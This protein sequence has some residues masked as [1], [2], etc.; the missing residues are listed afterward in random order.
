MTRDYFYII[1]IGAWSHL[2]HRCPGLF[3]LWFFAGGKFTN[4]DQCYTG[5]FFQ[6]VLF[7]ASL[8][9]CNLPFFY[10]NSTDSQSA[11][12]LYCKS[13]DVVNCKCTDSSVHILFSANRRSTA[14]RQR[15]CTDIPLVMLLSL[16]LRVSLGF[17]YIFTCLSSSNKLFAWHLVW[18]LSETWEWKEDLLLFLAWEK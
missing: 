17:S 10:F 13:T 11:D 2:L 9:Y 1:V 15:G 18:I 4:S 16:L 8:F 6:Y 12:I 5:V 7:F 3:R 14:A